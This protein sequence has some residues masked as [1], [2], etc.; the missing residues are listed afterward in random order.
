MKKISGVVLSLLFIVIFAFGCTYADSATLNTINT[1]YENI[2]SNEQYKNV[3]FKGNYLALTYN[4]K[5][6]SAIANTSGNLSEKER[7]FT[8][9]KTSS[10]VEDYLNC[11][12]YGLLSYAVNTTYLSNLSTLNIQANNNKVSQ[13]LKTEMYNKLDTLEK[14]VKDLK[15][16]KE[17]LESIFDDDSRDFQEITKTTLTQ[18][19]LDGYLNS[20]NNTLYT[21][22]EFNNLAF[23]ALESI[24]P[25]ELENIN[26]L[27]EISNS[28]VNSLTANAVLLISNYILCYDIKLRNDLVK[29]SY[30]VNLI[31][32]LKQVLNLSKYN[33]SSAK[34]ND[35]KNFK[36]ICVD[37]KGVLDNEKLFKQAI[38]GLQK[39]DF[40]ETELDSSKQARINVVEDYKTN[41]INYLN[42]LINYLNNIKDAN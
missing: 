4:G 5:L 31:N 26:L 29:E 12:H 22:L 21:L 9:L 13:N 17:F 35:I 24:Q 40:L 33:Y 2:T 16:Q 11:S 19:T 25:R 6:N 14:N 15:T 1:K 30:D 3:L 20:L 27:T 23:D 32:L 38:S 7:K 34:A 18:D 10:N 39:N 8:L 41:L 37:E 28:D 42:K 36:L